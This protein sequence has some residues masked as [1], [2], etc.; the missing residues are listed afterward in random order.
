MKIL[1]RHQLEI[2]ASQDNKSLKQ[3][4]AQHLHRLPRRV[5]RLTWQC[6]LAAA[7]L[8]PQ[9]Q[10]GCGIYLASHYPSR[11]TMGSLLNSVCID[12][13]QPKPFEFVNSVSNAAGFYLAQLLELEGPNLCLGSHAHIWPQL[14]QLA[15]SDL[16]A[17][18]VSQALLIN[19]QEDPAGNATL[20]VLLAEGEAGCK[21]LDK[22]KDES[23]TSLQL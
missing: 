13:L 1:A 11:D 17:G 21:M 22:A 14:L 3:Q 4:L 5:D 10:S 23:F 7:P 8:K 2:P 9:L 18:L 20:D 12:R 19:C 15:H 16:T 6:L